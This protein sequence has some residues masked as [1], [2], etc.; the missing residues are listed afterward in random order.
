M[1]LE[2]RLVHTFLSILI[3]APFSLLSQTTK[4]FTISGHLDGLENGVVVKVGNRFEDWHIP[5]WTDSC[6]VANGNFNFKIDEVPGGP[7]GYEIVFYSGINGRSFGQFIDFPH[8]DAHW[9]GFM[10]E[11]GDKIIISG[12]AN[13]WKN[14]KI[15]GSRSNDAWM[16]VSSLV[17]Y[18]NRRNI[19]INHS[20]R[21]I[22]DSIGYDRKLVEELVK[23]K[24][25]I[26]RY[27]DSATKNV[28]PAYHVGIPNLIAG[29]HDHFAGYHG[30]FQKEL[31]DRLPFAIQNS[32]SGKQV[33]SFAQLSIG[34]PFPDFSLPTPDGTKI[35]LKDF[36]GKNKITL[37]QFWGT[38][39]FNRE[40]FQ[41]EL[42]AMYKKFHAK[43]LA[44]IAVSADTTKDDWEFMI[45]Q[46]KYPW[47]N[48]IAEPRG[49]GEGSLINDVYGE[50]GHSIPNTTNILI[51]DKGI[52][53][54]WDVYGPELQYYLEK[55]LGS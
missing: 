22:Q 11:N 37:V 29:L 5:V 23:S 2:R 33:R 47:T 10:A 24:E 41:M 15:S 19:A 35:N 18:A 9:L 1:Q 3:T 51:D 39:S 26:A 43:G 28:P 52:I 14:I 50:G 12:K 48:V 6:V 54:A 17:Q 20:L 49:C 45:H 25:G 36:A 8:R 30:Y 55:Y 27:L 13:S 31:Y 4:G 46:K 32:F 44:V 7:R 16:W 34:Q 21:K 40:H 38:G 53:L 42:K